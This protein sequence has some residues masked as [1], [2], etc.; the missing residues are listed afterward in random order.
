[1]TTTDTKNTRTKLP[2]PVYAAAGAGDYAYQQLRKLP[3]RVVELRERV[4]ASEVDLRTDVQRLRKAARRNAAALV[5]AT[6]AAQDRAAALYSDLVVRGEHLVGG[7]RT[8][9]RVKATV[10]VKPAAAVTESSEQ[11]AAKP[12]AKKATR[13]AAPRA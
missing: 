6:Q 10:E 4:V 9:L 11:G 13:P 8:P 7:A 1:M 2:N 5:T 12:A 3:A